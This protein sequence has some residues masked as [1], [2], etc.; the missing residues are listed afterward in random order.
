MQGPETKTRK[1]REA[2][3]V[4]ITDSLLKEEIKTMV[5][6]PNKDLHLNY[7][8]WYKK[9]DNNDWGITIKGFPDKKF[10]T[11]HTY[12]ITWFADK[13]EEGKLLGLKPANHCANQTEGIYGEGFEKLLS[14]YNKYKK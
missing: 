6:L 3:Y 1:P 11:Q 13:D 7:V 14:I 5:V 12:K 8:L 9:E 4:N 2:N 10:G